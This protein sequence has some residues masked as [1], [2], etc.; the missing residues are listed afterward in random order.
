M[1]LLTLGKGRQ[2]ML[3]DRGDPMELLKKVTF[4]IRNFDRIW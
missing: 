2:P 1:A 4:K 3:G